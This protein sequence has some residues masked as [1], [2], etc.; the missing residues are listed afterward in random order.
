[1]LSFT[2][3]VKSVDVHV[4]EKVKL[5]IDKILKKEIKYFRR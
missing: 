4:P 3:K 1:M 5:Y 2:D